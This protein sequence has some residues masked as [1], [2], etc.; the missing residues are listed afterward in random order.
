M[1]GVLIVAHEKKII[2]R[3]RKIMA[4]LKDVDTVFTSS[5]KEAMNRQKTA[6]FDLVIADE[7]LSDMTGIEFL[8]Q[9]VKVNPIVNTALVSSLSHDDFH[10]ATEGL[11]VLGQIP[12]EPDWVHIEEIFN[13]LSKIMNLSTQKVNRKGGVE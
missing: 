5:G 4:D 7:A 13:N 2:D 1:L 11:G 3:M 8:K 12:V 9:L 6:R 10:E